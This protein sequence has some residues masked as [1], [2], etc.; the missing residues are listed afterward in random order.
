MVKPNV[1]KAIKNLKEIKE[2]AEGFPASSKMR[3]VD[4]CITKTLKELGAGKE[5]DKKQPA[6]PPSLVVDT[7]NKAEK[8]ATKAAIKATTKETADAGEE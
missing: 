1:K 4:E 6:K 8:A 3:W 2:Y 5:P 7:V